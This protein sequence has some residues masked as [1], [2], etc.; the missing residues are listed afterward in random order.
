MQHQQPPNPHLFPLSQFPPPHNQRNN[1]NESRRMP[2]KMLIRLPQPRGQ[3]VQFPY[4][5][6]RMPVI[7]PLREARAYP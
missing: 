2:H 7:P 3:T 4:I 1:Q 6:M 5:A